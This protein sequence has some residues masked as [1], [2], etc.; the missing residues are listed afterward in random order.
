MTLQDFEKEIWS[1][2]YLIRMSVEQIIEP[3]V[4]KCGLTVQQGYVLIGIYKGNISN[5]TD[6]CTLIRMNQSNASAICIKLED[7]GLIKKEKNPSNKRKVNL[8]VTDAGREKMKLFESY[9]EQF[10]PLLEEI[11]EEE[12]EKIRHVHRRMLEMMEQM[13]KIVE[14]QK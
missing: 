8:I 12:I 9:L 2:A 13:K 7:L 6:I 1:S 10:S 11:S 5:V 3:I 14:E 4:K